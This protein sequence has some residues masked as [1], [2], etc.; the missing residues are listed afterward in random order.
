MKN[1][2][3]T[4][5]VAAVTGA[6]PC[7]GCHAGAGGD[8]EAL[9]P[10]EQAAA[11]CGPEGLIDDGEDNNNQALV[12][13][14]RSGYWYTFVDESG[15]TVEPAAGRLGGTFTMSEGGANGSAYAARFWGTV[16]SGAELYAG[17]GMN[18]VDPKDAYDAS[19]YG[20]IS[21]LAKKGPGTG[22][23]RLKVP[24]VNTDPDGK[25]CKQC[26]ND[27]GVTLELTETWTRYVVPFSVMRQDAGWGSPTPGSI[28]RSKIY[29]IQFQV[30]QSG[31]SYDIWIDD[32]AFTGC[33]AG[34]AQTAAEP[35][36]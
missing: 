35:T 4:L 28:T 24:D 31:Q 16:G 30:N 22:S 29:G 17:M 3:G 12:Q 19:A 34:A 27:F 1:R 21:F 32:V 6:V 8:A 13:G 18:L 15:S 36:Q 26:Y 5:I 33:G 14:G 9:P 7:F 11:E 20:G 10:P 2:A 23:V 25:V